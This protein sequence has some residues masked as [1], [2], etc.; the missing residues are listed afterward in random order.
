MAEEALDNQKAKMAHPM[1]SS[2]PLSA[3]LL[4]CAQHALVQRDDCCKNG[5]YS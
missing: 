2:H 5:D 1:A 4:V 3:V